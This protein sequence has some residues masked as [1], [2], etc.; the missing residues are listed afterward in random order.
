MATGYCQGQNA[1]SRSFDIVDFPDPQMKWCPQCRQWLS[2][3]KFSKD[4]A[5][6]DGYNCRCKLCDN[7]YGHIKHM[8]KNFKHIPEDL[9]PDGA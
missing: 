3:E 2:R 5:Q 7:R 6:A 4:K 1:K 9:K 8:N